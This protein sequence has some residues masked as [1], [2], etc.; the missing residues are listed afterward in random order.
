MGM[1]WE[2]DWC[3]ILL[4]KVRMGNGVVSGVKRRLNYFST[5]ILNGGFRSK[6]INAFLKNYAWRDFN[7]V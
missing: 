7:Q 5:M 3:W 2:I 1:P 6:M 4:L